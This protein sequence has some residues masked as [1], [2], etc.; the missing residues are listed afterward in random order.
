MF[1]KAK[2]FME[3]HLKAFGVDPLPP[4]LEVT[5]K[6]MAFRLERVGGVIIIGR[7]ADIM[8]MPMA[9]WLV[10]IGSALLHQAGSDLAT[11]HFGPEADRDD[12]YKQLADDFFYIA[13]LASIYQCYLQNPLEAYCIYDE[14]I[15]RKDEGSLHSIAVALGLSHPRGLA[16]MGFEKTEHA[17]IFEEADF[18]K[19]VI[20]QKRPDLA[21]L[22]A[23]QNAWQKQKGTGIKITKEGKVVRFS[24]A[25]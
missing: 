14:A 2:S 1:E 12:T 7:D 24:N 20:T 4:I 17:D 18:F 23:L 8:R 10:V 15:E 9:E 6:G 19:P 13:D 5:G 3:D 22:I 25:D 21:L 11:L 16:S